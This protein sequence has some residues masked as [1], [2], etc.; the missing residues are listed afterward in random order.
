MKSKNKLK[1]NHLHLFLLLF[2]FIGFFSYLSNNIFSS[3]ESASWQSGSVLSKGSGSDGDGGDNSGDDDDDSDDDGDEN[4]NDEDEDENDEEDNDNDNDSSGSGSSGSGSGSSGSGSSK[5]GSSETSKTRTVVRNPD[6]TITET[7]REIKSNG[8]LKVE[9]RTYNAQGIKIREE[10]SEIEEG[11]EKSEVKEFDDTG[12][13][14]SDIELKTEDGKKIELKI[15]QGEENESKVKFDVDNQELKIETEGTQPGGLASAE[16]QLKIRTS[17]NNF[18]LTRAGADAT[19]QFP[20]IVDTVTGQVSVSTPNGT[21]LLGA[22]PDTIVE[23]A[24]P[25]VSTVNNVSLDSSST[26]V[27]TYTVLG[28]KSGRFLG[29][30]N[31][32]IPKT[33]VFDATTGEHVATE[34]TFINRVLELFSF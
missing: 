9:V 8:E 30:F 24:R 16:S 3:G 27:L 28:Q 15:K 4:E 1:F 23:K 20:M 19:S 26:N 22:M 25:I 13:K 21:I 29:V 12:L 18:R 17:G 33:V 14:L 7:K 6:G 32:Q 31:L 5:S 11:K 34:E 2:L 10:K